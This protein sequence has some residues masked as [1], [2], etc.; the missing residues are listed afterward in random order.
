MTQQRPKLS[1][2]ILIENLREI[3]KNEA[4][5]FTP[6]LARPENL[7]LLGESVGVEID[8]E[9]IQTE[10]SIGPYFADIYAH[11]VDAG[12]RII[13]ENQLTSSN[14]EH[15]GKLL[16][17]AA[18]KDASIIIWIVQTATDEHR[19][20]VEWLNQNF[21]NDKEKSLFLIEMQVWKVGNEM[22]P[23]F[24]VVERPNE[25]AKSI[26]DYSDLTPMDK[27]KL[28]FWTEFNNYL[29]LNNPHLFHL[30]KPN[31]GHYYRIYFGS[32]EAV[33]E[34]SVI[35]REKS[36]GVELLIKDNK[37]LYNSLYQE[38][39]EVENA[40]QSTIRWYNDKTKKAARLMVRRSFDLKNEEEWN[41]AFDWF[42]EY[43]AKMLNF[44][45][46]R[47]TQKY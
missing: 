17:Y 47:L 29:R 44:F 13:I 36:I 34:L 1:K 14:H 21:A 39:I 41:Q 23:H 7:A 40:I 27:L 6:W 26:R 31:K 4:K 37:E 2:K 43:G 45:K 28:N 30:N 11:E 35:P 19:K 20:A 10:L 32:K 46:H 15:L 33:L 9:S 42:C 8:E 16:T 38:R 25:W 12:R 5:D 22:A 18:G 24:N 3:W